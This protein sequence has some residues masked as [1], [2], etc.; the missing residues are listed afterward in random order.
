[1]EALLVLMAKA[2]IMASIMAF[3]ILLVNQVFRKYTTAK[4]RYYVWVIILIRLALPINFETSIGVSFKNMERSV[5]QEVQLQNKYEVK[6]IAEAVSVP[7]AETVQVEAKAPITP[8]WVLTFIWLVGIAVY[9]FTQTFSRM[10]FVRKLSKEKMLWDSRTSELFLKVKREM[11]IEKNI[12]LLTHQKI[13]SP[14]LFSWL[15]PKLILPRDMSESLT[16][17]ELIFIFRHELI[18]YKRKDLMVF[19]VLNILRA[20][21]WF[22]PLVWYVFKKIEESCEEA[23]DTEV[24]KMLAVPQYK[25]YGIALLK[26]ISKTPRRNFAVA[27][28]NAGKN[29]E[30]TKR[31]ITMISNFKN[32]KMNRVILVSLAIVLAVIATSLFSNRKAQ[33]QNEQ[34]QT[35]A[36]TESQ[37][38]NPTPVAQELTITIDREKNQITI[39]KTSKVN[40]VDDIVQV[41]KYWDKEYNFTVGDAYSSEVYDMNGKLLNTISVT[42]TP[43]NTEIVA[44]SNKIIAFEAT[45]DANN[46]YFTA[47]NPKD[48]YEHILVID[49]SHGGTDSGSTVTY[50]DP[51]KDFTRIY[52]EK[53]LAYRLASTIQAIATVIPDSGIK[54]YLTRD[55]DENVE[56]ADRAAFANEFGGVCVNLHYNYASSLV[57]A[58]GTESYYS[59]QNAEAKKLAELIQTNL[60]TALQTKDNGARPDDSLYMLKNVNVPLVSLEVAYLSNPQ[61]LELIISDDFAEKVGLSILNSVRKYYG[62]DDEISVT[63][64]FA[65]KEQQSNAPKELTLENFNFVSDL[66]VGEDKVEHVSKMNFAIRVDVE[67]DFNGEERQLL[68]KNGPEII[69]M[70][71]KLLE[72][73]TYEKV[74]SEGFTS[75][76]ENEMKDLINEKLQTK[77]VRGIFITDFIIQ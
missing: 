71:K 60:T 10:V 52:E 72:Q 19:S 46:I 58:S 75:E 16:D 51:G 29:Y 27:S 21:Y 70:A 36:Q 64:I 42:G 35:N 23:C 66:L 43:D 22:N 55:Q 74:I 26:V 15:A 24:L 34:E 77:A 32:K 57:E 11:G 47:K 45:E 20:L 25:D 7:L 37:V 17:D 30:E 38:E 41:D 2:S 56:L 12:P 63:G 31:R 9:F 65:D 48:V 33:A 69:R 1:M 3:I 40:S 5:V 62:M 14:S 8:L 76:Y 67:E 61:D 4:F 59:P 68:I 54:V 13:T 53:Y 50:D 39:P 44:N 49:P 73:S 28:L 6:P 18:H